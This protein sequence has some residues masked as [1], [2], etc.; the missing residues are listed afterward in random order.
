MQESFSEIRKID[1][2]KPKMK[3]L[4]RLE[5]LEVIPNQTVVSAKLDGEFDLLSYTRG[6]ESYVLNKWG[7]RRQNFPALNQF[8][9]A[10]NKTSVSHAELLC[11]LHAKENGKPTNLPTFMRFIKGKDKQ[12][13][14]IH[15]GIWNLIKIDNYSPKESYIWK[16]GEVERWIKDCTHVSVV[17]YITP[18][19]VQDVKDFW[20]VYVE[21][22]GYE[23]L[24]IR[25]GNQIY[26]IKPCLEVDAVIIGL[27][28]KT[29]H[30][31]ELKR[32]K[33]GQV[34]SI[35][36]ALMQA[37]GTFIELS[38]C[39]VCSE[40][41]SKA[42]GKLLDFKV[43]EDDRTVYVKPIVV[44]TI[45]YIDI[46]QKDRQVLKF[47]GEKY[48]KIGMKKLVSL[49]SPNLVRFRPDK[50]VNPQD[51]R[52]SQIPQGKPLKFH[53]YQGDCK[54]ILPT[55]PSQT[56]D[57]IITSPPYWKVKEYSGIEGEIGREPLQEYIDN[58]LS[59]FRECY[60]LLKPNGLMI[61]NIDNGKR[62][63]GFL[64]IS[65]WD[66]IKPLREIG[67]GLTQTIIW[68]DNTKRP[69]KHPRLLDHHYEPIFIL[70]KGKNYT[71]NWQETSHKGD[72]WHI[73]HFKG[74]AQDK[75]DQWDRMG[76][77]TFPVA[78]IEQLI[79][80]GSKAGD[81]TLDLFAGSGTVMDEAQRLGRNNTSIEISPNYCQTII[82]RCF[83]KHKLH[84]YFFSVDKQNQTT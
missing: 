68:V 9:E 82:K 46:F 35:K 67:F 28:K 37:D 1:K 73:H 40:E 27:N 41:V 57:L 50:S 62:E 65:A 15:I 59:V 10:M 58:M 76:I 6:G 66:W 70:A 38:D 61:L 34:T 30:G 72:A 64:T 32:F 29:S 4:E 77:A 8:V 25:N 43:G 19:T 18:H 7:H 56:I 79:I 54:S 47:D 48:T 84:K 16:L 55:I 13:N 81:W 17:P 12:L 52:T 22:K 21:E 26:K 53:L 3:T 44:C 2:F 71:W 60:R 83:D 33:E 24:V 78:L 69:L 80:L 14:K 20:R 75:G 63:D 51:L 31:K 39:A 74:Y 5:V 36:L 23:G 42:L 45:E 49:K 11:E